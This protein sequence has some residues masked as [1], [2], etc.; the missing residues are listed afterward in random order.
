MYK[1]SSITNILPVI[2][3]L[4]A[5][6]AFFIFSISLLISLIKERAS[7]SKNIIEYA[8]SLLLSTVGFILISTAAYGIFFQVTDYIVP[9][10]N[11]DYKIVSGEITDLT[12]EEN[13]GPVSFSV[14]G[15]DFEFNPKSIL[16]LGIKNPNYVEYN[17]NVVIKYV[18]AN[19]IIVDSGEEINVIMEIEIIN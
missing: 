2:L 5:Y 1:F 7:L 13:R 17:D 9:Y 15:T 6:I 12:K 14:D 16:Y 3:I 10:E 18:T 11:G 4:C 8:V 19:D